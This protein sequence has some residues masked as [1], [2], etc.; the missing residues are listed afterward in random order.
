MPFLV[1]APERFGLQHGAVID[2]PASHHDIMPTL[3]EMAGAPIPVTVEGRSLLPLMPGETQNWREFVHIEHAPYHH[4]LTDGR[5]T[6]I[7]SPRDGS[8][9]FFDLTTDREEH[10]DLSADPAWADIIAVW[11]ERLVQRLRGRPE[12]FS[13][14]AQLIPGRPHGALIPGR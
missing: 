2:A 7:W 10:Y 8:E 12:G 1:R 9:Q 4:A 6:Y 5:A 3:L 14:G 11:R 13:D